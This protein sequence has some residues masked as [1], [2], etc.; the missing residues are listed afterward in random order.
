MLDFAKNIA[1]EA[2]SLIV[3]A[4]DQPPHYHEKV[5]FADLVTDTDKQ[6]EDLVKS[7]ILETYSDHKIIA[8]ES[9]SGRSILTS[10]PTWIV[11]PIDG[12]SNFV[13]KWVPRFLQLFS[14]LHNALI[15]TD[16]GGDRNASNLDTKAAN[17]RRLISEARGV[18]TMGSAALHMCQVAAGQGDVFFEFGI[19]CWDYAAAS[20]IVTEAGGY[21]CNVDGGPVDLMARHCVAASSKQLAEV[22]CQKIVPISYPRD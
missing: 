8:E 10:D 12:T 18:R 7:R 5:S 4:F 17:I 21:C 22:I 9:A 11:D 1:K 20:L 19:H 15:L 14:E 13:S 3:S 16:W 2:G 6:V